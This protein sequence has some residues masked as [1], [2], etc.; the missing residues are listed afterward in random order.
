MMWYLALI[1]PEVASADFHRLWA[2]Y[3]AASSHFYVLILFSLQ[4]YIR[5]SLWVTCIFGCAQSLWQFIWE[6]GFIL[7]SRTQYTLHIA[8]TSIFY[9][10]LAFS[11]TVKK[12]ESHIDVNKNV[13]IFCHWIG[14]E[15]RKTCNNISWELLNESYFGEKWILCTEKLNWCSFMMNVFLLGLFKFLIIFTVITLFPFKYYNF[16]S[17]FCTFLRKILEYYSWYSI[18]TGND[19]RTQ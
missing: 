9:S 1:W 11:N 6:V 3:V 19:D 18:Q 15:T 16:W 4:N 17:Q 7:V 5:L 2:L 12:H 8:K 10:I 13:F 14:C